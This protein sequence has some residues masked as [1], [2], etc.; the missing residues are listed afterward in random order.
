MASPLTLFAQRKKLVE[1][2]YAGALGAAALFL[3]NHPLW[4]Q[5]V[6]DWLQLGLIVG[7]LFVIFYDE[8]VREPALDQASQSVAQFLVYWKW[9]WCL[10][11]ALYLIFASRNTVDAIHGDVL[12]VWYWKTGLNLLANTTNNFQSLC[13]FL[14][15]IVMTSKTTGDQR[16]PTRVASHVLLTIIITLAGLELMFAVLAPQ[17]FKA[18]ND[19]HSNSIWEMAGILFSTASGLFAGVAFCLLFGR[20]GSHYLRIGTT[21]IAILYLYA[22][23]QPLFPLFRI[24]TTYSPLG[25]EVVQVIQ[26]LLKILAAMLKL[27][28]FIRVR[29]IVK[30]GRLTYFM[31]KIAEDEIIV[32]RDYQQQVDL[33]D[34]LPANMR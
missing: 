11:L 12:D 2:C 31:K 5:A 32:V 7:L 29:E 26:I 8:H 23:I 16:T 14:M 25:K 30:T 24:V 22:T 17:L 10:W 21:W 28:L 34:T 4:I 9:L 15:F 13:I 20:L 6:L 18:A 33:A 19:P 27:I 1:I 3:R